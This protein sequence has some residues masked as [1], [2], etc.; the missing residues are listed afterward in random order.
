VVAT[1]DAA[2]HTIGV[3]TTNIDALTLRLEDSR[4]G[5]GGEVSLAID[6]T[7]V[8]GP[9]PAIVHVAKAEGGWKVGEWPA[10]ARA[11]RHGVQGPI[12]DAF[13]S[14]FLAVYG[15]GDKDL[16]IAELDAIRNPPGPLDIHGDFPM[17]PAAKVT[18]EDAAAQNLIL[19]GTPETNAVLK[20]IAGS[21]PPALMRSQDG[22]RTIFIY[23]NP[24]N[25]ERYVVVW[26]AKLLSAPEQ[27]KYGWIM[28]LSLL[29]DYV[30]VKDG[31]V[32][33]GGHFDS[34]WK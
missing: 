30:C 7:P 28:P 6:G 1:A 31:K 27:L 33:E 3:T 32:V 8:A 16:A 24:E 19:F 18:K 14:R 5:K 10:A 15:D 20:R 11:K 17:K 29:P 4:A 25:L 26:Q 22:A 21:L 12:D 9:L 23:P 13:N 34:D 2:K